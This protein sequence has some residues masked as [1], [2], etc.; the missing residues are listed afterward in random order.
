MKTIL[1]TA[2]ASLMA[3]A[4][5]RPT[6]ATLLTTVLLSLGVVEVAFS[7]QIQDG[8][9]LPTAGLSGEK[10][11]KLDGTAWDHHEF[12]GKVHLIFYVDPD[13][14]KQGEQLEERLEG[15]KFPGN[16]VHSS[17]VINMAATSMPNFMIGMTLSA[18]QK[19][20]P[21]TTY[22]KDFSRQLVTSWGLADNA[23]NF[24]IINRKGQLAYLKTGQ[25]TK[26]E[27]S[28]IVSK[29]RELIAAQ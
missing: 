29:I 7:A 28:A 22:A 25:P 8:S 14:R 19:R 15:E 4:S 27:L 9:P 26:D 21:H 1:L 6:F 20:Y 10:G 24:I 11:G 16:D 17:A 5:I 12:L 3:R 2:T 18:K 13:E 23:Y